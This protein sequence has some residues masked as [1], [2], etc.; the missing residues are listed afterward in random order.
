V[1]VDDDF[2]TGLDPRWSVTRP[3]GGLVETVNATLRLELRGAV[4]GAYSD[5]QIDDYSGRAPQP[6]RPP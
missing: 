5:A 3:G 1:N 6:W 2:S 4:A